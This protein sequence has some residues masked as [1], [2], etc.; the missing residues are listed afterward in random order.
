MSLQSK[1]PV[2]FN[3]QYYQDDGV[4]VKSLAAYDTVTLLLTSLDYSTTAHVTGAFV[5]Q[6]GGTVTAAYQFPSPGRWAAQFVASIGA[7]V[8]GNTSVLY[9]SESSTQTVL[10]NVS[11][12]G[13]NT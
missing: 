10:P 2:T 8:V 12:A 3:Y 13:T 9:G 6:T 5:S 11:V 1:N 4:T 7:P